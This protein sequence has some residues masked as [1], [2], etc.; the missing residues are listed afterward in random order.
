MKKLIS[1]VLC[2]ATILTLTSC[3]QKTNKNVKNY[4]EKREQVPYAGALMPTLEELGEYSDI[5]FAYRYQY[6]IMFET[7][8]IAL[9]VEYA[10]NVYETKKAEALASYKFLEKTKISSDGKEYLSPSA[11]FSYRGYAFQ[12]AP[13]P[14]NPYID[15]ER[16][17]C[18]SFALI[19]F[20]DEAHK[21]AYCY[22]YD[23]DL[24]CIDTTE[25]TEEEMM[26]DFIEESF[27]WNDIES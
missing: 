9:F 8:T 6:I 12:T 3:F 17:L 18:K 25:K 11:S 21:I 7:E 5:S 2:L 20:D 14:E 13:N 19:G 22:F 24:D 23:L 15:T 27:F 26:A 4:E 1:I 10:D 16:E